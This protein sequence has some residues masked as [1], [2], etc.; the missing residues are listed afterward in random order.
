MPTISLLV[1]RSF[2]IDK[3]NIHFSVHNILFGVVFG[4]VF[5]AMY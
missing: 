1:K 3:E 2:C 4:A 5:G